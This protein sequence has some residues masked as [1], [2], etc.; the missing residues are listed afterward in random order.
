MYRNDSVVIYISSLVLTNN[1]I[2]S[3]MF[4][5]RTGEEGHFP[6]METFTEDI[7]LKLDPTRY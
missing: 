5:S 2:G 4:S 1:V 7:I 6:E 3:C